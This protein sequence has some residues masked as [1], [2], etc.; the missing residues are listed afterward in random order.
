MYR[1]ECTC[2][3]ITILK[4]DF[5]GQIGYILD[6]TQKYPKLREKNGVMALPTPLLWFCEISEIP[7]IEARGNVNKAKEKGSCVRQK[8]KLF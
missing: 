8:S 5:T 3:V 2:R 1:L 4:C 6:P 7:K